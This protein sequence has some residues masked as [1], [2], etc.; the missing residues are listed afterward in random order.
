VRTAIPVHI[1]SL[2]ASEACPQIGMNAMVDTV[3]IDVVQTDGGTDD[4]GHVP[5]TT[6]TPTGKEGHDVSIEA[7]VRCLHP[8]SPP[9]PPP[10]LPH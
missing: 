3:V 2:D 1:R 5:F 9:P 10:H 7:L 8:P 6:T 4:N